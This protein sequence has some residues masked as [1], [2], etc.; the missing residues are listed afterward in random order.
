MRLL[1]VEDNTA[2]REPLAQSLREAGYGQ[3][4]PPGARSGRWCLVRHRQLPPRLASR[5]SAPGQR[6]WKLRPGGGLRALWPEAALVAPP[7]M[8]ASR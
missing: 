5:F 2:L 3:Q 4:H 8:S 1:L 6:V 7:A